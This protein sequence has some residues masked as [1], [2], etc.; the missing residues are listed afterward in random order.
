MTFTNPVEG[1]I[2]QMYPKGSVMQLYGANPHLY[3]GLG[4]NGI[5]IVPRLSRSC[6][7]AH[8]GNVQEAKYIGP[9]NPYG[10]MVTVLSARSA[11]GI[12]YLTLYGHLQSFC[13][14]KGQAIK[15]GQKLGEVGNSGFV[16]SGNVRYWNNAPTD[17]GVHLHFTL[18]VFLNGVLIPGA[19]GG[20]ESDPMPYLTG[21]HKLTILIENGD[22]YVVSETGA[23]LLINA[24]RDLHTLI[25]LG[26]VDGVADPEKVIPNPTL[27]IIEK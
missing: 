18:Y 7:A 12:Q 2:L 1:S 27:V 24:E 3:R 6:L 15:A 16:F 13:V 22:Q 11:D 9:T 4:H 21:M 5:D 17:K 19:M 25:A 8:D 26:F 23:K 10:N 20:A 14:A